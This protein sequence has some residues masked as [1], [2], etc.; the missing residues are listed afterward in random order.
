M[1]TTEKVYTIYTFSVM[2]TQGKISFY[3]MV[4]PTVKKKSDL[5]LT[6]KKHTDP[7]GS[8]SLTPYWYASKCT[9]KCTFQIANS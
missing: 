8:E 5:D 4:D 9:L 2:L 3:G 7:T 1:L 6:P